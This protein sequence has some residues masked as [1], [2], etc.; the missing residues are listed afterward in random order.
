LPERKERRREFR[1]FMPYPYKPSHG[2]ARDTNTLSS[3][4]LEDLVR[5]PERLQ[6]FSI[7]RIQILLIRWGSGW[8]WLI[9]H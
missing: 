1:V 4:L 8:S 9:D 5:K 3:V 6:Q 7:G 2:M